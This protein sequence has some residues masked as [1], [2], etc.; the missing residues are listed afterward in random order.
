M[1]KTLMIIDA[2]NFL[3]S[4]YFALPNLTHNELPVGAVY[5]FINILL[6]HL[7]NK[8][9]YLVIALD[10]GKSTFREA[11]YR[12]YKA[13][14][15]PVPGN[16][17]PQFALLRECI[18]VLN[19]NSIEIDGFEADDIIATLVTKFRH[20]DLTIK[21]L[22]SDKDL[23]QLV[24][25]NVYIINP[26]KNKIIGIHEVKEKFGVL[27]RQ[28][29]DFLSLIGDPS[30]NVPG[31]PGIGTK[32][33][34]KLLN[35][36]ENIENFNL[37]EISPTR[38]RENLIKY[39]EQ[40][41]L[42]K[43]LVS[44]THDI[45]I[46][47]SL[48]SLCYREQEE[49]KLLPFLQKYGF[50]NL[51][52][53][54]IK[55]K[56]EQPRPAT[57]LTKEIDRFILAAKYEGQI[58]LYKE[59]D[60]IIFSTQKLSIEENLSEVEKLLKDKSIKK[61]FH[62]D[63]IP[64]P[65]PENNSFDDIKVMAY[66]LDTL[67]TGL[68]YLFLHYLKE[69]SEEMFPRRLHELYGKIYSEM[70]KEKVLTLYY[71]V[72][73][74]LI[75]IVRT[76]EKNGLLIDVEQ[77][78]LLSEQISEERKKVEAKIFSTVGQTF[79]L[80]SPKQIGEMLFEKMKIPVQKKLRTGLASTDSEVL[81]SLSNQGYKI[82]D[83]LLLWRHHDKLQTAYIEPLL[84]KVG[85]SVQSH[86]IST[87]Y[88]TTLTLT[89]RLSSSN[90]NFQNIP[91]DKSVRKIFIAKEGYQF[92]CADYSQIELR[93]LAHIANVEQLKNALAS[94][95]DL[96]TLTATQIFKTNEITSELRN[97]AKAVNFGIIYGITSFGLSKQLSI[98]KEEAALYIDKYFAEY[99]EIKDYM[100]R[101]KSQAKRD[102]YVKTLMQ[103][104]CPIQNINSDNHTRMLV[105]ERS[106]INAPVQ[107]TA[108][109]I[110][111]MAMVRIAKDKELLSLLIMQVH[112][113]LVFEVKT[114]DLQRIAKKVKE[115]MEKSP[116]ITLLAELKHGP[117]LD[118]L[119]ELT[120]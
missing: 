63:N 37:D 7:K 95:T 112:D 10:N 26:I 45:D 116:D 47:H 44:L 14:R 110:I 32:T 65:Y 12:D 20:D 15:P 51:I 67:N 4:A 1:S 87:T 18:D 115:I 53:K 23:T 21:I 33:A 55:N 96:H 101:I 11:I 43:S 28:M 106:A 81:K 83:D 70:F 104:K 71:K 39:S 52:P 36:F 76:I 60:K 120:L 6:K 68:E 119:H 89:G 73:K 84:L 90:P 117:S 61:I 57:N 92:L 24:N 42:S 41:A 29:R 79:A 22:S 82:A 107:G 2:Y 5:G 19:L 109:D 34:A 56:P 108:A 25:E 48:D 17:T 103:R 100:S 31:V 80:K 72:D 94:G 111:R 118:E 88:S 50:K 99:P 13:N 105:A 64:H 27:P 98:S 8:P 58:S 93:I 102:T 85:S 66:I 62:S 74:P 75:H 38:I 16:L 40:L 113:E 97:R 49:K 59:E 91:R 30:D 69:A 46:E 3:F 78:R 114:S 35:T 86:R 54:L 77:L 9:D